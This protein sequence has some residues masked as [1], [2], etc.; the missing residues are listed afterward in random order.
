LNR[1]FTDPLP[2]VQLWNVPIMV[3]MKV[4]HKSCETHSLKA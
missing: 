1:G 3:D 2:G 4:L